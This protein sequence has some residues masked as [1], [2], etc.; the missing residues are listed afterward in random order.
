MKIYSIKDRL[1]EHYRQAFMGPDDKAVMAAV[2]TQVNQPETH[3]DIAYAPHH[4]EIWAFGE[5]LED[6]TIRPKK[7]FI[8][9]CA[10]LLRGRVRESGGEATRD[11]QTGGPAGLSEATASRAGDPPRADAGAVPHGTSKQN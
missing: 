3:S 7:E 11:A 1:I 6:G 4:F 5:I 9:D 8:C 2:A 10:S